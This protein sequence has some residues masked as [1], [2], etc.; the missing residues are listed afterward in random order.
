MNERIKGTLCG[1]LAAIFYGT[2]PLGAINLY[3]DGLTA[4]SVLVY[5]FGIA[6]MILGI[7]MLAQRKSFT[8]NLHELKILI[9]LG[10]LMGASSSTLYISFNYMD[11]GIASTL[12][13]VYPVM[14]A[15]I[16]A[17]MFH[18]KVTKTTLLSIMLCICGI[19]LLNQT[20][21]GTTLSILGITLVMISSLTY[22][23]YI[24]VVNKSSMRMSSI[25]LT[26]YV[27]LFGVITIL[28]INA[29]MNEST[30]MLTTIKQWA[31][32][33]QLAVMP[34][35]LS[36]ILMVV[37]VHN[38]GSTPTAI[39]GAIEPITA[40]AIG[41]LVFG[42]NFTLRLAFGIVLI[43]TSVLLIICGKSLTP[44]KIT[45]VINSLGRSIAKTW[46][47]KS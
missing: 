1:I 15:V 46:R 45:T 39:M 36:M 13:F 16:M 32:A 22:A 25:K 27:L 12:L 4:N 19:M 31:Y 11:V 17:A 21:D 29:A 5:R 38:I 30:Q 26:F 24:V 6:A 9:C 8:I 44:H 20:S 14:V 34:T 47:W 2:N 40:V 37:A 23:V 33:V 43:L 3:K 41:V 42:E 10:I 18:E 35:V 7:T 28:C